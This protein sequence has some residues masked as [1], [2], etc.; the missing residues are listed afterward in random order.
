MLAAQAGLSAAENGA[1]RV[2][3]LFDAG[4]AS[5]SDLEAA[6]AQ[7]SAAQAARRQCGR[8]AKPRER[9]C[10]ATRCA[11]P[12]H[13]LGEQGAG[14]RR[15]TGPRSVIASSPSSTTRTLELSATVPAEALAL[16]Q[17]GS[18][19][20][21][22]VDGYPERDLRGEGRS[23]QPHD[24]T[25]DPPGSDLHASAQPGRTAG[26]RPLRQRTGPG[27]GPRDR[28]WQHPSERSARKDRSRWSIGY[29]EDGPSGFRSGPV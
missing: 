7:R 24:G 10:R 4:A 8:D 6:E 26:R 2:K 23:G 13:R 18:T 1:R 22:H 27:R 25:G 16:V 5:S 28:P 3:K 21:F 20:R 15:A 12:D 19:I 9:G 29:A 17:P 14:A 11:E